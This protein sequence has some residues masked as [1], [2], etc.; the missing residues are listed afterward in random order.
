MR[1]S[2][3]SKYAPADPVLSYAAE[4]KPIWAPNRVG[5]SRGAVWGPFQF[6]SVFRRREDLGVSKQGRC[7]RPVDAR[8]ISPIEIQNLF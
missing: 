4:C 7:A 6:Q 8:R 3:R 5:T 1:V 2:S